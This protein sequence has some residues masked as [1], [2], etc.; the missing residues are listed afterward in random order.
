M[1]FHGKGSR[2]L[3]G[4]ASFSG[5]LREFEQ[6]EEVELADSTV[7]GDEGHRYLAGLE[8]GS[9]STS[10]LLDNV[11][12]AGGQDATLDAALG[13]SA[14]TLITVAPGGLALGARVRCIEAREVNYPKSSSV[15]DVVSFTAA[16][17][18]E[19]QVDYGRSLHDNTA[20]TATAN[21]ANVDHGALT[22]GGAALYLHVTA[23]TRS[24]S[25]TIKVQHSVDNS[26]WVD[27]GSAF[28]AVGAGLT[29]AQRV[30][31]A[32]TVNRHLRAVWTLTAGT[33]SITFAV[34]AAR[35]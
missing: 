12:T 15:G 34:T 5:Y 2:L 35:R 6:S 20:E 32:G 8:Q 10:G 21:G 25:T 31:A 4:T 29:S 16:W 28:T 14:G 7:F 30:I 33:G 9:L 22:S 3:L 18:S 17:Q 11:A 1:A 24:T 26:V 13:A 27:L 23:N 19:G